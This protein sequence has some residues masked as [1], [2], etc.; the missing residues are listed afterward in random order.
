MVKNNNP[1]V[2]HVYGKNTANFF[3]RDKKMHCRIIKR[4]GYIAC[5]ESLSCRKVLEQH[6]AWYDPLFIVESPV[7]IGNL[8]NISRCFYEYDNSSTR[9][10]KPCMLRSLLKS[11]IVLL[12]VFFWKMYV[13][14]WQASSPDLN[15]FNVLSIWLPS[16]SL[17]LQRRKTVQ[18]TACPCGYPCSSNSPA[19]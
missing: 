13:T 6:L 11:L 16:G 10:C 14:D 1:E 12:V 5:K 15:I 9:T 17:L 7:N 19:L 8:I 4:K 18:K 2:V 3:A